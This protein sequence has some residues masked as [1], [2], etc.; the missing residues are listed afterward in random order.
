M[1]LDAVTASSNLDVPGTELRQRT[2]QLRLASQTLIVVR[3]T[4]VSIEKRP[5]VLLAVV[6]LRYRVIVSCQRRYA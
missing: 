6:E 5:F 1:D 3:Q 2:V 4:I